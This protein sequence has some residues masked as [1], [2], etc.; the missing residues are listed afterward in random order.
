M[1]KNKQGFFKIGAL[2]LFALVLVACNGE[3][4]G[5]TNDENG[6]VAVGVSGQ[7]DEL[8]VAVSGEV[9]NLDPHGAAF[10][11]AAQVQIHVFSRL[12]NRDANMNFV[13]GLATE[14]RQIDP[15]TWEFDLRD[16]V[17]FHNGQH[18]TA[19]DVAFTFTRGATA[20]ATIPLLGMIDPD[21][22]EVIN[23]YQ[24]RIGT[25]FPFAPF[26]AHMAHRGASILNAYALEDVGL[27]DAIG[28]LVIGTGPY[29]IIEDIVG[30]RLVMERWEDYH[31]EAPNMRLITYQIIAD[32]QQRGIAA[33]TAGVD[34]VLGPTSSDINRLREDPNLQ[35]LYTP[36]FGLEYVVLNTEY[37]P[38]SDPLVRQAINYAVNTEAIVAASSD[39]TESA[40]ASFISPTVFGHDPS[41][42]NTPY[43]LERA[44]A[45]MIEAGFSGEA[46][47]A[48]I[49]FDLV[50]NGESAIRVQIAQIIAH[51]LAQIGID[52][53]TPV[54]EH[55][56]MIQSLT[57]SEISAA[58]S[59]WSVSTGDADNALFS[60]LHSSARAPSLNY[61]LL[62]SPEFDALVESAREA[63][64]E[65]ARI[66]Y[67]LQAQEVLRE[68]APWIPL[69]NPNIWA[70]A[71]ENVRGFTPFPDQTHIF[72]NVYFE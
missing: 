38:L 39:G 57:D 24:I 1:F 42:Q 56:V 54:M 51:D 71:Q 60:L 67:Y 29:Q 37:G 28:D 5:G 19:Y 49:S 53:S 40:T 14:W 33:E 25:H 21:Q 68:E 58:V 7:P 46:N 6:D 72:S 20:P 47:A 34:I 66:A 48:D 61:S 32:P 2:V 26:L 11:S 69:F 23:D 65:E 22:I 45:L 9:A 52:V 10:I 55:Q 16:D 50:S 44:R 15:L 64:S 4:N 35:V 12:V 36:G 43:D 8:I 31:G 70:I 3:T 63:D 27:G 62:N 17:Y 30:D 18:M 59:G 13:P 41:F